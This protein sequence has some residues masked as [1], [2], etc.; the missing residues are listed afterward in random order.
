M[1]EVTTYGQHYYDP[2]LPSCGA[3]FWGLPPHSTPAAPKR[4]AECDHQDGWCVYEKLWS[5][6]DVQWHSRTTAGHARW[7]HTRWVA[8]MDVCSSDV[9]VSGTSAPGSLPSPGV[10]SA[11]SVS[12][13]PT[14]IFTF[15]IPGC[16]GVSC[17]MENTLVWHA[18]HQAAKHSLSAGMPRYSKATCKA[19]LRLKCMHSNRR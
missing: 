16:T 11:V 6:Q 10:Q 9:Q 17:D 5:Q 13:M 19:I 1:I 14:P 2:N 3:L 18:L 7:K 4:A 8:W 15:C 12:V